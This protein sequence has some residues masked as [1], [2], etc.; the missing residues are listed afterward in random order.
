MT[1]KSFL[2]TSLFALGSITLAQ[3]KPG[4]GKGKRPHLSEEKKAELIQKFDADG[5]GELNEEER[6]N[7]REAM[8]AEMLAKYDT[9]GDG[10][11]SKEEKTAAFKARM[12][13]KYDTDGD[14]EI[15]ED[16]RAAARED[17]GEKGKPKKRKGGK[18]D[19]I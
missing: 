1:T 9:D 10:E 6:G 2:L 11:L 5:D 8:K 14:G 19:D 12:L 16:E 7:A 17:R 3:A 13:E 15:S 18:E 4:E